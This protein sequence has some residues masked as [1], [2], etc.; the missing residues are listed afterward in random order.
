MNPII[1]VKKVCFSYRENK[2]ILKNVDFQIHS[3]QLVSLLG[4]N[5]VGK[6]TLLNCICGLLNPNSG[7]IQLCGQDITNVS[8]KNIAQTIAYVPKKRPYHLIIRSE[9]L[10]LWDVLHI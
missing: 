3:G 4:P 2:E 10:W 5:G 8:R 9:I 6:S 7:T 1:D